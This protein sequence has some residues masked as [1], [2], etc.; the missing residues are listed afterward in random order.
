MSVLITSQVLLWIAVVVLSL[1][2]LALARQIGVLH[3]RIAPVGALKVDTGPAVG[4]KAPVFTLSTVG[5][6]LAHIGQALQ[7]GRAQLLLFVSPD[8]P[9]CK[10]LIP[11]ARSFA[12]Y[13]RLSVLFVSDGEL[14]AQRRMI[15]RFG[16]DPGTFVNSAEVGMRFGVGKLPYAVLID[17]A[18]VVAASGLVNSR[19]HLESLVVA[20]QMGV[21]SVQA[22][23]RSA[24]SAP[25]AHTHSAQ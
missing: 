22:Y 1:I 14:A 15:E 11:L 8:C 19:E 25:H 20:K 7:E 24:T 3:E 9:V 23:L 17:D 21:P 5:G 12:Q 18:G 4:D 6:E 2:V 10:N 16:L 13:E